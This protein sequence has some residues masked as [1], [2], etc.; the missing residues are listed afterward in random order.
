MLSL[1]HGVIFAHWESTLL[2]FQNLTFVDCVARV[3]GGGIEFRG[4]ETQ[5][6]VVMGKFLELGVF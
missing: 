1:R 5:T 4:S 2:E 6:R 3:S